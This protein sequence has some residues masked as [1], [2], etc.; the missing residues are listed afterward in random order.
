MNLTLTKERAIEAYNKADKLGKDLLK[1]LLG[2]EVFVSINPMETV[3]NFVDVCEAE[4]VNCMDY[5]VRDSWTPAEKV[6]M[7]LKRLK[8]IAKVFNGDWK[9]NI[10]DTNQIKH[11]PWF[12]ILPGSGPLGF[13]LS[14]YDSFCDLDS[15]YLGARL[16]YKSEA[17]SIYVGKQFLEEYEGLANNEN[18]CFQ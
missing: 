8:L 2:K 10:A 5:E 16:Y 13:R 3:K 9:P 7:Y 17:I 14:F 4:G 15:S 12:K 6:T 18:L 11:Y 1:N